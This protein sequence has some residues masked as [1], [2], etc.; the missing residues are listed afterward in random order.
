MLCSGP[1]NSPCVRRRKRPASSAF[2]HGGP[3]ICSRKTA[4]F[5]DVSVVTGVSIKVTSDPE[6]R[7]TVRAV[8]V[9]RR[10]GSLCVRMEEDSWGAGDRRM[11]WLTHASTLSSATIGSATANILALSLR[12]S[13]NTAA[14]IVAEESFVAGVGH[15][16]SKLA[17]V[18]GKKYGVVG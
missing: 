12:K 18:F 5:T 4:V 17:Y 3:R 13:A 1:R 6:R 9:Q 14:E 16:C 10:K 11:I 2:V 8:D 7:R 15:G